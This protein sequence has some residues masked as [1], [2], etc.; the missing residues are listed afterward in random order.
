M[1]KKLMMMVLVGL[2]LGGCSSGGG[3]QWSAGNSPSECANQIVQGKVP[4]SEQH[5]YIQKCSAG[6]RAAHDDDDGSIKFTPSHKD[7]PGQ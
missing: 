1:S 6:Y 3:V 2:L 5:E 7:E 4:A